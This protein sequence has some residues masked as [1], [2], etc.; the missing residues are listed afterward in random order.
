MPRRC[1]EGLQLQTTSS[2]SSLPTMQSN[3]QAVLRGTWRHTPECTG[4]KGTLKLYS[5]STISPLNSSC[6]KKPKDGRTYHKY[7]QRRCSHRTECLQP[8]PPHSPTCPIFSQAPSTSTTR[9]VHRLGITTTIHLLPGQLAYYDV[10]TTDRLC[11]S[12]SLL[13]SRIVTLGFIIARLCCCQYHIKAPHI[14]AL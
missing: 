14:H 2:A 6:H 4:F 13:Y 9:L 11:R 1:C 5:S 10:K 7:H 8:Q 3:W 12:L